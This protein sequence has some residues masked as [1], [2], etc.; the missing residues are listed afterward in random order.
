VIKVAGGAL[1]VAVVVAVIAELPAPR[2]SAGGPSPNPTAAPFQRPTIPPRPSN[3]PCRE[4]LQAEVDAAT[5]GGVIDLSG[6]RYR[7]GA[8]V[9]KPLTIVGATVEVPPGEAGITVTADDV[10]LDS[11]AII[12][13]QSQTFVFEEMGVYALATS[14][15]P[16]R[17]LTIRDSTIATLGGFGTYL[18][19]VADVHVVGNQVDDV[20]YAGLMVLSGAGG[21][22]EANT[23]RRIG[24]VGSEA[25]YG[26]AYGIVLTTQGTTEPPSSDFL[27]TRNTVEDVPT[28]HAFDTHGGRRI[29]FSENTVRGSPRPFFITMDKAGNQPTSITITGNQIL[30]PAPIDT[31]LAAVTLYRAQNVAIV[32]NTASGWNEANFLR[33][34]ED[35]STRV[36]VIDNRIVP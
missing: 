32:R 11:I 23:V 25:N 29:V 1:A 31:N 21:T 28:W 9:G 27:V 7:S 14:A 20:V 4:T 2:G 18:S 5:A 30:S 15:A 33:D 22:I 24:V 16:I 35:Q 19:N 17:R 13:S 12:G 8:I 10:T 6:C 26:N 3:Q 34:F 36:V